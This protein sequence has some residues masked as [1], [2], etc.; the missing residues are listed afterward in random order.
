MLLELDWPEFDDRYTDA[1]CY[2]LCIPQV[3]SAKWLSI[4]D[5]VLMLNPDAPD[6][7]RIKYDKATVCI[8]ILE[9]AAADLLDVTY[10]PPCF[11][12]DCIGENYGDP[13][14]FHIHPAKFFMLISYGNQCNKLRQS[15][16]FSC[17]KL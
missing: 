15:L 16:H 8:R 9:Y 13:A 7:S 3:P 4:E 14:D 12:G 1:I 5:V 17:T 6:L 2:E 10:N 11:Q